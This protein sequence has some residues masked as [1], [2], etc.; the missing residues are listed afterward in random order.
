MSRRVERTVLAA[1]AVALLVWAGLLCFLWTPGGRVLTN[2][3]VMRVDL[4]LR[5][6]AQPFL[7]TGDLVWLPLQSWVYGS[8][9]ALTRGRFAENPMLLAAIINAM[10]NGL[11][12][13]LIGRAAWLLFGSA[14]GAFLAFVAVLFSP[15]LIV[16]ALSGLSEPLYY[17]AVAVVIWALAAR[18]SGGGL[19]TVAIGSLGVAAGAAV[20]YE[21][22]FLAPVWLALVGVT[23]LPSDWRRPLSVARAAWRGRTVLIVAAA[24]FVVPAGWMALNAIRRGDPLAFRHTTAA[25]FEAGGGEVLFLSVLERLAYYPRGLLVSAPL[26]LPV[27]VI[28]GVVGVWAAPRS[29][30]VTTL[31]VLHF[32]LFYLTSLQSAVGLF[33]ERFLF[34]FVLALTPLLAMLPGLPVGRPRGRIAVIVL[35]VG[36][37]LAETAVGLAHPSEE[38]TPAPDLRETSA[39]LG[40]LARAG[41][42]R[43][44]VVYGEGLDADAVFLQVPNGRRVIVGEAPDDPSRAGEVADVW[45][46]RLPRRIRALALEPRLVVGRYHL[47]GALPGASD[48]GTRNEWRRVDEDG[49]EVTLRPR[50]LVGLEFTAD[51]PPPRAEAFVERLVPRLDRLQRG[52]LALRWMYGH[53]VNLGRI[54]VEARVDG[55]VIFRSDVGAPS[56]WHSVD[57]EIPRG[58]G[59]S[60]VTV[61]VRTT[62]R[63]EGGW[64]WGRNSTVIVRDFATAPR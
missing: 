50:K 18:Q 61:A 22:W 39:L 20:R 3:D 35:L 55:R 51:N 2:D 30:L 6:A 15:W 10:A 11:A 9:F 63:V 49:V 38:W 4:G 47:Y 31:V 62:D 21:G 54:T 5:W 27:L 46:E 42:T 17:L 64:S 57:L 43:L 34:A 44:R 29:R 60:T 13:M 53:G 58:V 7:G 24:P 12:A 52:S 14:V 48:A 1:A 45:I 33:V 56:R 16:T 28:L 23:L 19:S 59:N 32:G 36:L 37:L 8:A 26:L 25:M 40:R 41:S